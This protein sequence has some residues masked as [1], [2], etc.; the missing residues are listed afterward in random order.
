MKSKLLK[1]FAV[2]G[3]T[4]V[5]A[6]SGTASASCSYDSEYNSEES[7]EK[8]GLQCHTYHSPESPFIW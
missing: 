2:L 1:I 8:A 6:I 4:G 3:V 7:N 5:L